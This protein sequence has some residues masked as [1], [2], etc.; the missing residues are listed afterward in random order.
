MVNLLWQKWRWH[1]QLVQARNKDHSALVEKYLSSF[2]EQIDTPINDIEFVVL[3]METNSL[4]F[5][6]ANLLALGWVTIDNLQIDL[7]SAQHHVICQSEHLEKSNV[8]VHQIVDSELA[9][10]EPIKYI[11]ERFLH[12]ITGKVLVAHHATIEMQMLNRLFKQHLHVELPMIFIDTQQIAVKHAQKLGN[13]IAPQSFHLPQLRQQY[14]LPPFECHNAL[15]DAIATAELLIAQIK[16]ATDG[17]SLPLSQL[18][19]MS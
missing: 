3:D 6:H 8:L 4:D 19:N 15:A 11:L 18:L 13:E 9:C 12:V 5:A 1:R 7:G 2:P 14:E 17:K 16:H 10:G